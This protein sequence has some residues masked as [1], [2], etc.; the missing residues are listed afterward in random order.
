MTSRTQ[1]FAT[2]FLGWAASVFSR[3]EIVGGPVPP[4][5]VL[6]TPNHLNALMDPL[7]IFRVAGRSTS[8]LAKAPLFDQRILGGILR[9]LG[10]LPVYRRQ[11]DPSQMGRNE[12]TFRGAIDA[13]HRGAAI[14][15]FPEGKSH[16]EPSL[17]TLRTGAARIALRAEAEREG[18]LGVQIVPIGL[19]YE[20]KQRFRGRVLAEIGAPI[21]VAPWMARYHE[22]EVSAAK[23]LTE[24][25]ARRLREVTLN[26]E[27]AEDLGLLVA[28]ARLYTREKGLHRW[29]EREAM[30][31]HVPRLRRLAG[32]L[33]WLRA[34]DLPRHDR[35]AAAVREY[36]HIARFAGAR[37]GDVPPGYRATAVARY[38]VRE[39]GALLLGLPLALIGTVVWY[40]TWLAPQ[41]VVPRIGPNPDPVATY[42][43]ATGM[44]VAPI[45]VAAVV[46]AGW[47]I[48]GWVGALLCGIAAPILG[49]IALSWRE[50]WS[51]VS[52]D[53]GLFFAILLRPRLRARV[54]ERRRELVAEFDSIL[55]ER[56]MEPGDPAGEQPAVD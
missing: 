23:E 48:W 17:E 31:D 4:G 32:H 16:S 53:V 35:L 2:G 1:R 24:E 19:T 39:G 13:L 40:P 38:L 51:R 28:A 33:E 21:A 18:G 14:Q 30:A 34:Q 45:T 42:K 3:I 49:L 6:V 26:L 41:W 50:R 7:V 54:A 37:E 52:E 56:G 22:D 27:H 12:E 25:I 11:D 29:R 46:V 36:E 20:G 43:L 15:I 9:A 44:F 10:G 8:P 47:W 55:E 5:P